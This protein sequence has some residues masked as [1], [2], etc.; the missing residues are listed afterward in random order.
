M[1]LLI[2]GLHER[3]YDDD[4]TRLRPVF[5]V[6]IELSVAYLA[7]GECNQLGRGLQ[8][9]AG[10][11]NEVLHE[12]NLCEWLLAANGCWWQ[13]CNLGSGEHTVKQSGPE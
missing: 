4:L 6:G 8:A 11:V 3:R 12:A 10:I 9:Q 13:L 2:D 7:I 5:R 1:K